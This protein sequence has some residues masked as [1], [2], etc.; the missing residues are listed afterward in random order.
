MLNSL[1]PHLSVWVLLILMFVGALAGFVDTLAGGGGMLTM[2]ALFIAGL[3][4]DS[5]IATNKLQG[6]FGTTCA[7]FYFIRRGHLNF[8][9]LFP[10]IC[11]CIAGAAIGATTIQ[12]LPK[13]WL[14]TAIPLLLLI[15][16]AIF[17]FMPTLGETERKARV[18]ARMFLFSAIIPIGF[19]DGFFGPGTGSF[20]L[21]T[22]ITLQGYTLQK[23]TIEAKLYNATTGLTSLSIFLLSGKVVWLAGLSM[24]IGQLVGARIASGMILSKGN[25]VIRPMVITMSVLMGIYLAY[26][27]W[28]P[29]FY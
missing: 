21:L 17:V 14:N 20:F 2:P 25:K 19:Y 15:I 3:P 24:A 13:D 5:A 11:A 9:R 29:L 16:A 4:P 1:S 8:K 27:N 12:L 22:L 26:K 28:G 18:S 6:C 7:S 23:A 10:N